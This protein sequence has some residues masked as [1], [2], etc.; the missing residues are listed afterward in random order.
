[1]IKKRVNNTYSRNVIISHIFLFK[2]SRLSQVGLFLVITCR[3]KNSM[4]FQDN[5]INY[6]FTDKVLQAEQF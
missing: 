4:C 1:M 6:K 2:S 5:F 3:Q